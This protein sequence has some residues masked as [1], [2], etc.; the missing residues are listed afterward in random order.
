MTPVS[1]PSRFLSLAL[2]LVPVTLGLSLLFLPAAGAAETA[3]AVMEGKVLDQTGAV[4]SGV[5]VTLVG[6]ATRQTTTDKEGRFRLS[7]PEGAYVLT[8]EKPGFMSYAAANLEL[9]AGTP[10]TQ[11]ISLEVARSEDVTV[12]EQAAGVSLGASE[13]AG[14]IVLKE[15]D[16]E[17]LPDDPDELASYLQAL[18]GNAGGPNGGQIYIDGFTGGR[19]PSKASIREIRMNSNPFSSEF[20]RMGFGRIEIITR[21]GSDRYRGAASFRF[22]NDDLN[23]RNPYALNEPHYSRED[24]GFE[25]AGP[26][27]KGKASFSF[28][29]DYRSS[30][31]NQTINAQILDE[32]LVV[33]PVAQTLTRPQSRF[34]FSPRVDWQLNEK[35]SLTM[36]YSHSKNESTDSG[37]GGYNLPSRGYDTSNFENNGDVTLNSILGKVV[38][39][40]R[41][42]YGATGRDS[43]AQSAAAGLVVQEA[44]SSGG[45]AVGSVTDGSRFELSDVLSWATK[46]H[47]FRSGFRIRRTT[48]DEANR[49]N[50]AGVVT[51]AGGVGPELDTN[52]NP[53]LGADGNPILGPVDSIE[54]YR[55]TLGLQA[56]GLT[57]SQIRLLGGGPSQ[58]LVAGGNPA[59]SVAQTDAGIFFNDDW[60]KSDRLVLGLGLRAEMQSNLASR[61]DLAPR[62]SF[63][64]SLKMNKDGRTPKTVTRGGIGVFY[65]RV[66]DSLTLDANRYLNGGRLQYVV[67][68]PDILDTIKVTNGSVTSAP[69]AEILNRFSQPQNTRVVDEDARAPRSIQGSLSLE[70]QMGKFTGSIA[71][72]A[73]R[74]DHQLRSRNINVIQPDGT[75]P[76]DVPAAVYAYETTGRNKQFQVVTGLGTRPGQRNSFFVR[77]FLGW[78]KGDTDGAGTFPA[79]PGDPAA[80]YGRAS[81]DVRHRVMAGGNIEGPWGIR[82]GPM[83]IMSTGRPY[84]ITTGRDTN[85]DTLYTDRPSFGQEGQIGAVDTEYGFLNTNGIGEII[86]RNYGEGP[87]FASLSLRISKTIPF[88]KA[89]A[90]TP[91]GGPG[92]GGPMM[93]GDHGGPMMGR[94]GFSGGGPGITFTINISN[95]TNRVNEG[96][97][98]GNLTSTDFGQ[99]KNLAGFFMGF[100]PGGGGGGG[101]DAGNRR[102]ELQAR[103]NF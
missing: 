82:F 51:F 44:F 76:L 52:F 60:K 5:K 48:T 11:E 37:I 70:Q 92:G 15:K 85:L 19:V 93:G 84:N 27:V 21:P 25:I 24:Y 72:I 1:F 80:D 55:R 61:V 99:S 57:P 4:V 63:A 50:F 17:A 74:G 86:P 78:M 83:L 38:N 32:N 58:Y 46:K 96:Q 71:F 43:I 14:A 64:Y 94:G 88:R 73:S 66:G 16:I 87:A 12:E 90:T 101:A 29:T 100:G 23:T 33:T 89:K 79:I 26:I 69:T 40:V 9:K 56:K 53:V 18:A 22:N 67:T 30:D 3:D 6:G 91:S 34:S 7:A 49:N 8:A 2:R 13:N 77:Y 75:R 39:E 20:D 31:D 10:L 98:V 97:P 28:D 42:R 62:V 81:G 68:D 41:M 103:I 36:R 54:R 45:A 65:D 47:A 95:L 59:A 35:H 102:I